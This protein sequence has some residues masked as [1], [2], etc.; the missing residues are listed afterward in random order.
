[1]NT[2]LG[3][4]SNVFSVFLIGWNCSE[5]MIPGFDW[6]VGVISQFSGAKRLGKWVGCYWILIQWICDAYD[7][8]VVGI[9]GPQGSVMWF[10]CSVEDSSLFSLLECTCVLC[11]IH[12]HTL[13][14]FTS[15]VFLCDWYSGRIHCLVYCRELGNGHF[16]SCRQLICSVSNLNVWQRLTQDS[17]GHP[18]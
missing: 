8:G 9:E 10:S 1:M 12:T 7:P 4:T 11:D 5:R 17:K 2:S 16:K 13:E 15:V 14:T 18:L 6:R 3:Q